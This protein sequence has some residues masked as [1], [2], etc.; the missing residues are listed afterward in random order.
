MGQSEVRLLKIIG[1]GSYGEVYE[2]KWK[3]RL[4]AAKR[5]H[6]DLF[7]YDPGGENGYVAQFLNECRLL[8]DLQ[9]P[10]IVELLSV[11]HREGNPPFLI[12]E[13]HDCN[14]EALV[15][16]SKSDPRDK[17]TT[18][19]IAKIFLDV[20]KGLS[21]LH[22]HGV[23][24]RDIAPKNILIDGKN[25]AKIA[26][27]GLAKLATDYNTP[28][29]GTM[30]YMA[31]ETYSSSI[32]SR[33]ARYGI[34]SDIYSFGVT[35]LE[36]IV[37]HPPQ[38]MENPLAHDQGKYIWVFLR[39]GSILAN[40]FVSQNKVSNRIS[41]SAVQSFVFVFV[42]CCVV[43]CCSVMS[44]RAVP[45]SAVSCP[46]VPCR[47][48]SCYVWLRSYCYVPCLVWPCYSEGRRL[49]FHQYLT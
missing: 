28:V 5:L 18:E 40:S 39:V 46:V 3:G 33:R 45:C 11:V 27:V 21:C 13:L 49:S 23:M 37:E 38:M 47:L 31:P 48:V 36:T 14:L 8:Q 35:L 16:K 24:H 41:W 6:A 29:P 44:C 30:A 42:L 34:K 20:A 10:Q 2:A 7:R 4:V 15:E 12:M 32:A 43:L 26:D 22:S 19:D 17:I 1:T 9:H 25:R